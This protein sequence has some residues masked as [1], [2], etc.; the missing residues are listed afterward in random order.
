MSKRG[1]PPCASLDE[2][3]HE[4]V[5]LIKHR[6]GVGRGGRWRK[7]LCGGWRARTGRP[8]RSDGGRRL[9]KRRRR[10][11]AVGTAVGQPGPATTDANLQ[12]SGDRQCRTRSDEANH[13]NVSTSCQH[14]RRPIIT[15]CQRG[16]AVRDALSVS[17]CRGVGSILAAVAPR[18]DR[19][20]AESKLL[21]DVVAAA[22]VRSTSS[23]S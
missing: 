12:G 10:S 20:Q 3:R 17:D 19:Q 2:N 8:R 13:G 4:I 15:E 16:R 7:Y 22:S 18:P 5:L 6:L 9:I 14:R 21:D 1:R 11:A 23:S